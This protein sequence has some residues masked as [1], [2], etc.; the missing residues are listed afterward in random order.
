M[1]SKCVLTFL[2][3]NW[4]QRFRDKK[5]ILNICQHMLTTIT[6]LQNRW[7]HVVERT[8]TSTKCQKMKNAR[9]KPAKLMFLMVKYANSVSLLHSLCLRRRGC[10]S[11]LLLNIYTTLKELLNQMPCSRLIDLVKNKLTTTSPLLLWIKLEIVFTRAAPAF[12]NL[13]MVMGCVFDINTV[14]KT[15]EKLAFQAF[16]WSSHSCK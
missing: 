13:F 16:Y 2:K 15:V 9:A 14:H 1:L 4:D 5:I 7:F 3:F 10:V 12:H 6:Q 8:R 11:S